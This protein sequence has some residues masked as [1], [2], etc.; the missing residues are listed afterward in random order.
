M[1]PKVA[2]AIS[3]GIDSLVAAYLLKSRGHPLLGLHFIT[4]FETRTSAAPDIPADPNLLDATAKHLRPLAAQLDLPLEV[5]DL[6]TTFRRIVVDYFTKAYTLGRTPNPCLVCNAGIKFGDLL[7]HARRRGAA[8]LATGHYARIMRDTQGLP[9][10]YKGV[11]AAKD[12]SYFLARLTRDQL[13]AARFPL[14]GLTKDRTRDI[15]REAGLTPLT[16]Q[17]SQD[18]CFIREGGYVQFLERHLSFRDTAGPVVDTTG[19]R[20]GIHKGL[21]RFT[22]GQRRG[23]GIPGPAP[24]YVVGLE[25]HANRLVVGAKMDLYQDACRVSEIN[26]IAAPP[27]DAIQVAARIRYRHQAAPARLAPL[28]SSSAEIRFTTPQKA[29]TPGQGAVFYAGDRVLGGGWITAAGALG[30]AHG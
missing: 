19:K 28:N 23:I 1:K 7:A 20:V 22:I 24:Y 17:E 4:G 30:T 9:Q 10:L 11:D 27:K 21:H 5:V 25:P 13:A 2:I 18:I 15:A 3:G 16:D 6:R 8:Y 29:V 26:W 14:G 12:Q